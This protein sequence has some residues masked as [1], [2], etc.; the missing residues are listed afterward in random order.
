MR[1]VFSLDGKTAKGSITA[2][3]DGGGEQVAMV[4]VL[5]HVST[6]VLTQ[7]SIVSGDEVAAASAALEDLS[8]VIDFSAGGGVLVTGDARHTVRATAAWLRERGAPYGSDLR[9]YAGAGIPTL[10][11]GP[12][13]VRLA[14]GPDEAVELDEVVRV[15]EALVL[16]VLRSCGT[17]G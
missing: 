11:Y 16:A 12:G 3:V 15:T 1:A 2:D 14:H 4:C 13:D 10:H 5:D 7:T 8:Q 9:L 6:L 17:A